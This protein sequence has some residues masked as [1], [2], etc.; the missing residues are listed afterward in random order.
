ME[1]LSF[2]PGAHRRLLSGDA[3]RA[4]AERRR[5]IQG[6]LSAHKKYGIAWLDQAC[7]LAIER[8]THNHRFV[9]RDLERNAQPPLRLRQVDPLIR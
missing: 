3:S 9:L 1:M 6:L 4:R 7:A 2:Y 8:E 5:R